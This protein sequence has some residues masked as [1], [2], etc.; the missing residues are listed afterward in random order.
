M[1]VPNPR[2]SIS[3]LQHVLTESERVDHED[4]GESDISVVA[5]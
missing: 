1:I 5:S 3:P 2:P 4:F